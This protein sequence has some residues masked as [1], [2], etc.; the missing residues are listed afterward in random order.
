MFFFCT[1]KEMSTCKNYSTSG[2]FTKPHTSE[3]RVCLLHLSTVVSAGQRNTNRHFIDANKDGLHD[4][5]QQ[6]FLGKTHDGLLNVYLKSKDKKMWFNSVCDLIC[7]L[8][9]VGSL[10]QQG[11]LLC[12]RW[13]DAGVLLG[14]AAACLT[15]TQKAS[16]DLK[17]IYASRVY[18]AV[19]AVYITGKAWFGLF[20]TP[21][22]ESFTAEK[23][24]QTPTS[25]IC[26]SSSLFE[27]NRNLVSTRL[28]VLACVTATGSPTWLI[29][30]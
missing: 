6:Q 26:S 27:R 4:E 5:V 24:R 16:N 7:W 3:H 2:Y 18:G 25:W 8:R 1:R 22:L 9:L 15:N 21:N 11:W 19:I 29:P 20:Q 10:R 23:Q 17:K 12:C 14:Q 28:F 30:P 13:G